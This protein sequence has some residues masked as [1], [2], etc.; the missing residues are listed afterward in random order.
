MAAS[1]FLM[2]SIKNSTFR[3]NSWAILPSRKSPYNGV[4]WFAVTLLRIQC[5]EFFATGETGLLVTDTVFAP[6]PA[7]TASVLATDGVVPVKEM[8]TTSVVSGDMEA[9]INCE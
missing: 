4:I 8:P 6:S 5:R 2:T 7:A 1:K 9:E 3:I